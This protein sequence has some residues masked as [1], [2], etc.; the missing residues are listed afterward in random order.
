MLFGKV[1]GS[2]ARK[3]WYVRDRFVSVS[4]SEPPLAKFK[5][6]ALCLEFTERG[7]QTPWHTSLQGVGLPRLWVPHSRPSLATPASRPQG[8]VLC[9]C[10]MNTLPCTASQRPLGQNPDPWTPLL[11]ELSFQMAV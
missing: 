7:F 4:V 2:L 3:E 1:P 9:V 5:A 8:S 6:E 10:V 11:K